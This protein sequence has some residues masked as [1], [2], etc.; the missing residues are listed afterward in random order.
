MIRRHADRSITRKHLSEG[1]AAI[2]VNPFGKGIRKGRGKVASRLNTDL[3]SEV[4]HGPFSA[5]RPYARLEPGWAACY[6]QRLPRQLGGDHHFRS[7]AHIEGGCIQG[8]GGHPGGV[9]RPGGRHVPPVPDRTNG[10]TIAG[11]LEMV[12]LW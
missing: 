3:T 1:T 12:H 6:P 5:F 11:L 4:P 7:S 2:S 8:R 10:S 9:V